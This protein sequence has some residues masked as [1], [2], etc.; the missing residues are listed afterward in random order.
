[1]I[2]MIL[3]AIP[4]EMC[5]DVLG[6]SSKT[7]PDRSPPH[8][9][10][11]LCHVAI[12]FNVMIGNFNI[13]LY[14]LLFTLLYWLPIPIVNYRKCSAKTQSLQWRTN[15]KTTGTFL[16]SS[17]RAIHDLNIVDSSSFPFHF[18]QVKGGTRMKLQQAPP[19]FSSLPTLGLLGRACLREVKISNKYSGVI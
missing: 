3:I 18:S 6:V 12:S 10:N 19:I 2:K 16:P 14:Y 7:Y 17:S 13:Y 8:P 15:I 1:M 4:I 5:A 11:W 9:V